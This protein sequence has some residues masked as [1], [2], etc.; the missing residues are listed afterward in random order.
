VKGGLA[1]RPEPWAW[2]SYL[3]YA[4]GDDCSVAIEKPKHIRRKQKRRTNLR[5][6]S[7]QSAT[8]I[9]EHRREELFIGLYEALQA[10]GHVGFH[11]VACIM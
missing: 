9:T 10:N 11:E 8:R 1:E 4:S 7:S 2:S 3:H 5:L 6:L